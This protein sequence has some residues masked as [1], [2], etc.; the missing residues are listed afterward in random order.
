MGDSQIPPVDIDWVI[1]RSSQLIL[2]DSEI[3][4][5]D[6]VEFGDLMLGN[7]EILSIDDGWFG[8][9]PINT[10]H[11]EIRRSPRVDTQGGLKKVTP[12]RYFP[13]SRPGWDFYL[14]CAR[15]L[16]TPHPA[17]LQS[18]V[19]TACGGRGL[20]TEVRAH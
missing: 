8:D 10:W 5:S 17:Q 4:P 18:Q 20:P 1:R 19:S 9:L 13:K 12:L 7:S 2:G 15:R 11:S 16:F 6:T 3:F 14:F